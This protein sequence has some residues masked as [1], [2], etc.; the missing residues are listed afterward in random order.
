[1]WKFKNNIQTHS[2]SKTCPLL[3]F[4]F[5]GMLIRCLCAPC[6]YTQTYTGT[7]LLRILS[8][9][10]ATSFG[11]PHPLNDLKFINSDFKF[12]HNIVSPLCLKN[13]WKITKSKTKY[14][15]QTKGTVNCVFKD[16]QFV[17]LFVCLYCLFHRLCCNN[18]QE[19]RASSL[20]RFL[21]HTQRRTTSVGLLWT[22]D[23]LV[24]ETSTWQHTTL[25]T[26]KYPCPPVGFEPTISESE[27][28]KTYALDRA[29]IGTG[30][31]LTVHN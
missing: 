27:Q 16:L 14:L 7:F 6:R 4:S 29:A 25:T 22:S 10:I 1:M 20:T 15:K 11:K 26:D 21:N 31:G 9:V 8:K 19:A 28:P 3:A 18:F 12:S 5:N 24:A 30:Q 17:C 23:Q 2:T 13:T